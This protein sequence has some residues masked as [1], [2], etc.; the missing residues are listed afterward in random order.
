MSHVTLGTARIVIVV[1]LVA[2]GI[3]VLSNGFTEPDSAVDV[4]ASAGTTGPSGDTGS[5]SPSASPA[6]TAEEPKAI[7]FAVFNGTEV[8]GL[9]ADAASFLKDAG[10]RESEEV[11]DAPTTGVTKTTVYFR[12]GAAKAQNKA[13]AAAIIQTLGVGNTR[14]LSR[15]VEGLVTD[16]TEI[17]VVLGADYE[18]KT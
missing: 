14:E 12:G 5:T 6:P 3:V 8:T 9:A 15:D 16:K 4:P 17:V 2:I 18:F 7:T 1:A 13:N 11:A 10:Y